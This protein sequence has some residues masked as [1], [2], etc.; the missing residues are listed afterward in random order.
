MLP[1]EHRRLPFLAARVAWLLLA[2]VWVCGFLASEQAQASY[3]SRGKTASGVFEEERPGRLWSFDHLEGRTVTGCFGGEYK[4]VLGRTVYCNGDPVNNLDPD[5]RFGKNMIEKSHTLRDSSSVGDNFAGM[6]YGLIGSLIT[7]P[8]AISDTFDQAGAGMAQARQEI[9]GYTGAQAFL[10]RSLMLAGDVSFGY[11]S[12][13]NAPIQTVAGIPQGLSSFADKIGSDFSNASFSIN[14]AFNIGEDA[15][16]ALGLATG[17][18][19]GLTASGITAPLEN[20]AAKSYLQVIK[21]AEWQ[22]YYN[23]FSPGTARLNVGLGGQTLFRAAN[24]TGA[25]AF[26]EFASIERP[27]SPADAIRGS[28][29]DPAL[30]GNRASQLFQVTT[31]PGLSLQGIAAPQ[32]VGYPGGFNQVFQ[33]SRTGI[34]TWSSVKPI[35][36]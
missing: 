17:A 19:R 3:G 26:G 10:A 15:L 29:L 9:S 18:A 11:S 6:G 14:S 12:L 8:F 33:S 5:G 20:F 31:R 36:Y 2:C 35:S 32:G 7:A 23:S 22:S 30:T 28:A 1:R 13:V 4:L 21:G 24:S 34:Q 25:G 16:G 27:I